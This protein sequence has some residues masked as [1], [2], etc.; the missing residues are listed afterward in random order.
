MRVVSDTSPL[1]YLILI[2]EIQILTDLFLEI[3]IPPAV[4][5]ELADP[6]APA[7][8]R[9]WIASPPDWLTVIDVE[10]GKEDQELRRL[11]PGEREAI[12]LA[13]HLDADLVILD[14]W[15]GREVAQARGLTI[16]GLIGLLCIA[17]ERKLV[18]PSGLVERLR[19]TTFRISDRLLEMLL[20]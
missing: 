3:A 19:A 9:D 1:C 11:D 6:D 10:P 12:Q 15:K 5:L 2:D 13:E 7:E 4:R 16:T 8:V 18:D 20:P 17:I 14:D